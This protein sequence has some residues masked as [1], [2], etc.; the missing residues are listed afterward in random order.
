MDSS[1]SVALSATLHCL[2]GCAIGEVLGMVIGTAADLAN[3][4]TIA[5]SMHSP[6][7]SAIR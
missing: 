6:S 3:G 2:A 7:Y 5:I 4:A 1:W